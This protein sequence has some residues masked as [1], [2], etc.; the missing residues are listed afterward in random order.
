M[1]TVSLKIEYRKTDE[2][3]PY[4]MNARTHSPEQVGQ[5]AASIKEFGFNN[6]ILLDGANGVIAGHGRLL[7]AQK[8]GLEQVPCIELS[9]L[10]EK[11]KRAYILADNKIALNSGWD[12]S[13]L[14]I[15]L[16]DLEEY[17]SVIG[18]SEEELNDL[19]VD[20]A[21]FPELSTEDAPHNKTISFSFDDV[22]DY[23]FVVSR[24]GTPP[25]GKR[26]EDVLI[27]LLRK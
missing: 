9:H 14:Q 15:E 7:A 11:Q 20:D 5:I 19:G 27:E 1:P 3:I 24:I 26:K 17:Q 18:F 2:L 4:A 16:A 8:L 10:S 22:A 12:T 21:D 23:D 25:K 13:F 6:P